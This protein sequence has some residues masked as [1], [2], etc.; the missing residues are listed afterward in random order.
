MKATTQGAQTQAQAALAAAKA[1]ATATMNA[2]KQQSSQAGKDTAAQVATAKSDTA[3]IL[4]GQNQEL[5]SW[6]EIVVRGFVVMVGLVLL[7]GVGWFMLKNEASS[8][9]RGLIL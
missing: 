6:K 8:L 1:M 5:N 9:A 7:A 3:S 2:Q 4:A